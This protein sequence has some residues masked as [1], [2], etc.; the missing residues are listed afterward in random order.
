MPSC[1]AVCANSVAAK[2]QL[3]LSRVTLFSPSDCFKNRRA[4]YAA[5]S[6]LPPACSTNGGLL[7]II[8]RLKHTK[9]AGF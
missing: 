5:V 7:E 9:I 6:T 1:G 2:L 8:Q 4:E 3:Y